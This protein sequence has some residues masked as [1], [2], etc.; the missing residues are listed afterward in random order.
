MRLPAVLLAAVLLVAIGVGSTSALV[1]Q[2]ETAIPDGNMY[3]GGSLALDGAG[4]PHVAYV[5]WHEDTGDGAVVYAGNDGTGWNARVL[6]DDDGYPSLAVDG[7]GNPRMSYYD[8]MTFSVR[9]LAF[10]GSAW[11]GDTVSGDDLCMPYSSLAL[12]G[13]GRPRISYGT[14]GNGPDPGAM[15]FAAFDG[16][17]WQV[18]TVDPAGGVES[19]LVLD[20]SGVPGVAYT[21]RDAAGNSVLK[22]A[23]LD[24]AA[25]TIETVATAPL[26][27]EEQLLGLL[28]HPSLALDGDA[29]PRITYVD[30]SSGEPR[31]GYASFDGAAW[32]VGAV[33]AAG[34]VGASPSLALDTAG[35]PRISYG[36]PAGELAFAWFDGSSWRIDV[37]DA[38]GDVGGWTS[39]ALDGAGTPWIAYS[40]G[41]D[42]KIAWA[43]ASPAEAVAALRAE[44]VALGLPAGIG[45][46]LMATLDAAGAALERGRETAAINTLKA[47]VN[48]VKAKTGKG[49]AAGEAAALVARANGIA[50]GI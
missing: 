13:G 38:A 8:V 30:A 33:G 48:Q 50:A 32:T 26:G 47:F 20:G 28:R 5:T 14:W 40:G 31:L 29:R 15:R 42:L 2:T 3:G 17:A 21:G 1:W 46:G 24:G 36:D 35:N 39:L 19:S 49:L 9:Y 7:A 27:D 4:H 22:Y 16:S 18:S 11:D 43:G 37:V 34:P 45:N 25:W 6:S 44:V 23:V 41:E 12:D 10:D